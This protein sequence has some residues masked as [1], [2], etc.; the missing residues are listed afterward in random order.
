MFLFC[1]LSWALHTKRLKK[2]ALY[3]DKFWSRVW[4]VPG[5]LFRLPLIVK[6]CPGTRFIYIYILNIIYITWYNLATATVASIDDVEDDFAT[7]IWI[8]WING[9]ESHHKNFGWPGYV[10]NNFLSLSFFS[11]V[12]KDFK[13]YLTFDLQTLRII[14]TLLLNHDKHIVI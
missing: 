11:R 3:L 8:E 6:R 13:K 10:V 7:D 5:P 12:S 14:C 1:F 4:N 2:Y 9:N